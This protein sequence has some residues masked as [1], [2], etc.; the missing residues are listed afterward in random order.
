MKTIVLILV[1]S[2]GLG[3]SLGLALAYARLGVWDA[4]SIWGA[5]EDPHATTAASRRP[6]PR[7]EIDRAEFH[8]GTMERGTTRSHVFSIRNTGNAPLRLDVGETT[9]KCTIGHVSHEQI[10][11]GDA[12]D[13][14]LE[15]S[16]KTGDGPF[17]QTATVL[18]NDPARSR[19]E[20][21]V[22]GEVKPS[23][24]IVPAEFNF[25]R[26]TFGD[27]RQASVVVLSY[28]SEELV[29]SEPE[30][31]NPE[32]S[33]YFDVEQS[34][35]A[36]SE[37]PDDAA[38]AGVRITLTTSSKLPVGHFHHWV[39]LHTNLPSAEKIEI[40]LVGRVVGDLSLFGRG[41][42]EDAGALR[43]GT[44]HSE[45]GAVSKLVLAIRGPHAGATDVMVESVDPQELQVNIGEPQ[46]IT[47]R[48]SHVP[49]TIEVPPGTRPMIR[50]STAQG[51]AGRIALKTTHPEAPLLEFRVFFAVEP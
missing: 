34:T 49:V 9:C 1:T 32:R 7:A 45:R 5:V 31:D 2:I 27:E 12:A 10:P 16:A 43:M 30:F 8:F 26:I 11:P 41:W 48:M 6:R 37:F 28:Q 13:V 29:V 24:T 20:L 4:S 14:R 19:I 25:G 15:W 46:A 18:T 3:A 51:D 39:G 38:R 44:V 36:K 50:L 23:T 47:E 40:P 35:L 33:S 17:R 21:S 22:V 42:D